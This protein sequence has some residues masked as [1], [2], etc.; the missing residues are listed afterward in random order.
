M[1]SS[2]K[3]AECA[4]WAQAEYAWL[5]GLADASGSFELTNLRVIWG[6]VAAVRRN[7]TIERLEQVFDEFNACGLLFRWESNGKRYG[8]WTGS[9]VPGRLPA[10][11]WRARLEKLAPPVPRAELAEYLARFSRGAKQAAA[12][13]AA[14]HLAERGAQDSA[15]GTAQGSTRS[16]LS[17]L[18]PGIEP[19]QAQD[20]NL[21]WNQNQ[22]QNQRGNSE[23][24][25]P[26]LPSS[27]PQTNSNTSSNHNQSQTSHRDCSNTDYRGTAEK[28][29]ARAARSLDPWASRA[30]GATG[31]R[32]T[33]PSPFSNESSRTNRRHSAPAQPTWW[34]SRQEAKATQLARDLN[35]GRGPQLPPLRAP[36]DAPAEKPEVRDEPVRAKGAANGH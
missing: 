17:A 26:F 29:F 31:D 9:D 30:E 24:R 14:Q 5:Y 3:L 1:W 20:L 36:R 16:S 25:L 12:Q 13:D 19:A 4:E 23:R 33:A 11:S 18:K 2:D 15:P 21:D 32:G 27:P 7:F 28:A 6:R 22:N 34:Q 10:P 35:V 8:H